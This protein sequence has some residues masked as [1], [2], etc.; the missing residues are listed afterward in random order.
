[1]EPDSLGGYHRDAARLI[2]GYLDV[3]VEIV[4]NTVRTD[5][6]PLVSLLDEALSTAA[7]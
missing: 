1:M 4:W 7:E 5:L 6:P 3:D 2:H